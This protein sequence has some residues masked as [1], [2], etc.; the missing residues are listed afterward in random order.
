MPPFIKP[1]YDISQLGIHRGATWFCRFSEHWLRSGRFTSMTARA[2]QHVDTVWFHNVGNIVLPE[3]FVFPAATTLVA[4]CC[5]KNFVYRNLFDYNLAKRF[6]NL[7]T[8]VCYSHPCEL[9]VPLSWQHAG[10]KHYDVFVPRYR[11]PLLD[12]FLEEPSNNFYELAPFDDVEAAREVL[13][14]D[15]YVPTHNRLLVL[16]HAIEGDEEFQ[17]FEELEKSPVLHGEEDP[18][19]IIKNDEFG[20]LWPTACSSHEY[21]VPLE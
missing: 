21:I 4:A 6:R 13:G 7:K 2:I 8:L 19:I 10:G 17:E 14:F 5:D 11:H 1:V 9:A 12:Y 3:N 15:P 20:A 18:M 16:P